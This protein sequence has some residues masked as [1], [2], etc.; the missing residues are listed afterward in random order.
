[1]LR[2]EGQELRGK[3]ILSLLPQFELNEI[4]ERLFGKGGVEY[5]PP[6][7]AAV[8]AFVV[9][10]KH[11]AIEYHDFGEAIHNGTSPEVDG[12]GG[13]KAVAAIVGAYESALAGRSVSMQSLLSGEVR[14]YQ[15]DIDA[16]LGLDAPVN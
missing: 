5:E 16:T 13:M 3:E 7:D 1:M 9:D 15:A 2:L 4:T 12:D 10:A 11:L 8:S 14:E 6:A